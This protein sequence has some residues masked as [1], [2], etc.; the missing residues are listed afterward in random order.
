MDAT[1][2]SLCMENHL[3]ILVFDLWAQGNI[4]RALLGQPIGTLVH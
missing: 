3:P 1:A 4:E 2:I